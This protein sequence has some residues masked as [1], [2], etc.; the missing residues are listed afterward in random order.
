MLQ[1]WLDA[2][3]PRRERPADELRVRRRGRR[4]TTAGPSGGGGVRLGPE[5]EPD[6]GR[7]QPSRRRALPAGPTSGDAY[8]PFLDFEDGDD[9][10]YVRLPRRRRALR[11]LVLSAGVLADR[12]SSVA[13][14]GGGLVGPAPGR[15]AR[16]A[17]RGRHR[18]RARGGQRQPDRRPARRGGGRSAAP[19]SSGSTSASRA[20]ARS[21]ASRPAP[22][23][24]TATPRMAE[25]LAALKAGPV[26]AAYADVTIPEGLRVDRLAPAWPTE[27]P[28]SAPRSVDAA[29]GTVRSPYQPARGRHPR[30]PGVP[31]HLPVR[32]AADRGRG[33]H[34]DGRQF[35]A[36]GRRARPR[37]SGPP[38][39]ATRPT[40]S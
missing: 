7:A 13:V 23:A 17:R 21:A 24:S 27:C 26:P 14:A 31:R 10:D 25:A 22:T 30:G 5:P 37:R 20:R 9:R 32:G 8:E 40:R 11:R 19:A 2:R 6:A 39:W 38:S 29:L 4:S 15:P 33:R 12:W 3:R 16:R 28:G 1:S 36:G 18:H 34:R 35:E